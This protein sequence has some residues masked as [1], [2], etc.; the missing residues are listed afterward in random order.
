[1]SKKRIRWADG[2]KGGSILAVVL[3]HTGIQSDVKSMAY[4]LC[5]PA[6]FF[7][8]GL[9]ADAGMDVR[10][11][12][13]RRT[14]RLLIPYL[15]F[16]ILAWL[17][18]LFVGRRYGS[19]AGTPAAWWEPLAGLFIGR[20]ERLVQDAPLWFLPCLIVIEWLYYLI[21]RLPSRWRWCAVIL[22]SVIGYCLGEVWQCRLPWGADTAMTL[23]PLYAAGHALRPWLLGLPSRTSPVRR[24]LLGVAVIACIIVAWYYNTGIKLSQGR[25]GHPAL[26]WMGEVS[27]VAFWYLFAR[28]MGYMPVLSQ[29]LCRIGRNTIWILCMHIPLFG[30]VK[31][32]LLVFG[33]PLS[34]YG[35]NE[36]SLLLWAGSLIVCMPLVRF[37]NRYLP[38]LGGRLPEKKV[39]E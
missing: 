28:G 30:A 19:D 25:Y 38:V 14:L 35:T 39:Q 9:F 37:L 5:L 12:F 34:F 21:A 1:M 29:L 18:W 11:Y 32:M 36:G 17:A 3:Y 27:V 7:V 24:I 23:L 4:L 16:G 22:S 10:A 6:F 2:M 15:A 26:F 8:A 33:V 20:S 31:G 13:R